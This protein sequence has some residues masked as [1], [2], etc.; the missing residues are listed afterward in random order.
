MWCCDQ[1][2][3][4]IA[5]ALGFSLGTQSFM[6]QA[7]CLGQVSVDR[8]WPHEHPCMRCHANRLFGA[9]IRLV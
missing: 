1:V 8:A 7:S 9:H 5:E 3:L 4:Y 6:S 2:H